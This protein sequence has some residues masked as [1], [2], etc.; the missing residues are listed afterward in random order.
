MREFSTGATR[1]TD[2]NKIDYWGF[3]SPLADFEFANYMHKHRKQAD[4]KMRDSDNWKKGIPID[5][6]QRSLYRHVQEWKAAIEDGRIEDALEIAQAMRFNI[7]GWTHEVV[8]SRRGSKAEMPVTGQ[9]TRLLGRSV[10]YDKT[11]E[12]DFRSA[13]RNKGLDKLSHSHRFH[14]DNKTL[15]GL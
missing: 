12:W 9:S 10:I 13:E 6:Y 4:G 5:S 8:K 7:Q 3:S 2:E 14:P 15:L 1:D 11:D